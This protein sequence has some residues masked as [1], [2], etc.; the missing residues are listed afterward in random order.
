MI[1]WFKN[2]HMR[3]NTDKNHLVVSGTKHPYSWTNIIDDKVWERRGTIDAIGNKL[4]F[5]GYFANICFKAKH[6]FNVNLIIILWPWCFVIEEPVIELTNK[7]QTIDFILLHVANEIISFAE[8]SK[9]LTQCAFKNTKVKANGKYHCDSTQA[10]GSI[11]QT[12][13]TGFLELGRIRYIAKRSF[14]MKYISNNIS[15]MQCLC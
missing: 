15:D 10:K 8:I 6:L 11:S 13:P 14:V 2:N 1:F 7:R 5:D 9:L 4:K 12:C 3:R